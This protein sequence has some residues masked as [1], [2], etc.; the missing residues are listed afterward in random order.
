MMSLG[1]CSPSDVITFDQNW[2]NLYLTSAGGKDLKNKNV[3]APVVATLFPFVFLLFSMLM[4]FPTFFMHLFFVLYVN[5]VPYVLCY[6]FMFIHQ[7]TLE[8][9]WFP[10][11]VF[12]AFGKP[13]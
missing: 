1:L 2:H 13:L 3:E 6:L 10:N 12:P 7:I 11:L 9:F 5:F 8:N 4:G